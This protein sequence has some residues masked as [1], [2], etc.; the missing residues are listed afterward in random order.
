MP[1][2]APVRRPVTPSSPAPDHD[3]DVAR[4]AREAI[5]RLSNAAPGAA[6][7]VTLIG[8][9]SRTARVIRAILDQLDDTRLAALVIEARGT[10]P[11]A[12]RSAVASRHAARRA[13]ETPLL[14]II[15]DAGRLSGALRHELEQAAE[16]AARFGGLAL[17]LADTDPLEPT[18]RSSGLVHL[19]ACLATVLTIAPVRQPAADAATG[20]DGDRAPL[21]PLPRSVR[22]DAPPAM[23]PGTRNPALLVLVAVAILAGLVLVIWLMLRP[24]GTGAPA[25][26]PGP[27]VQKSPLAPP[28]P[29][30]PPPSPPPPSAPEPAPLPPTPPPPPPVAAGPSLLLVAQPGDTLP[31]LY[32]KVYAGVEPPPFAQVQALN[33]SVRPGVRLVFPAPPSGW[34]A[35]PPPRP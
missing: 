14:L 35:Q 4:L 32:A 20:L 11:E 12:L 31:V 13:R 34:P 33:P 2:D 30:P 5:A 3:D 16:A 27:I 8:P 25:P 6:P 23:A 24:A 18:F 21:G 9:E 17:L 15:P 26:L 29:V 1:D 22:R 28:A 7:G 10:T 19:R